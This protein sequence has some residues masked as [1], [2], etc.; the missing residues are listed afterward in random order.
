M[1][2][3]YKYPHS[4][5]PYEEIR[6]ANAERS[7]KEPEYELVDTGIFNHNRYF[8]IFIEYAKDSPTDIYVRLTA[9]NRGNEQQVLHILPTLWSRNT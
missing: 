5:Y 2:Y 1:K 9:C 3:L 4:A 8:D 6:K 7:Q